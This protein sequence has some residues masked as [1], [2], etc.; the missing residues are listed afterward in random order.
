[1][2]QRAGVGIS[3]PYRRYREKE[4]MLHQLC[5]DGLKRFSATAERAA[6]ETEDWRAF[7]AFLTAVVEAGVHSACCWPAC[8]RPKPATCPDRPRGRPS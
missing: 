1:M 2:A 6:T 7:A 8:R 5:H 4:D 3:A